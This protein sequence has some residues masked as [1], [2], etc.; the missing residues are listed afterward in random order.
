MKTIRRHK[1][2]TRYT[3]AALVTMATMV[4]AANQWTGGGDNTNW[5][6][7]ANWSAGVPAADQEVSLASGNVL[8]TN[9][10]AELAAFTM[11]GGTLTFSNWTTR[12]RATEVV[13]TDTATLTHPAQS[14]T[15]TNTLGEWVPD[16][17]VW[18]VCSNFTL[19]VEAAI[20]ADEKG[21]AGSMGPGGGI[22]GQRQGGGSYGGRGGYGA[23]GRAVS[24]YGSVHA[25]VSPGSGGGYGVLNGG[26][27]GGAV[28]IQASGFVAIH[29]EI[30][31]N[32]QDYISG[33]AGGGSGG[34]IFIECEEFDASAGGLL[35]AKGGDGRTNTAG[36]GGGGRISVTYDRLTGEPTIRFATL[37]GIGVYDDQVS[38]RGWHLLA[39]C[40][41][42][43]V[44]DGT[45]IGDS[46]AS[47]RFDG[48]N[49][50]F[51][52]VS[53]WILDGLNIT[54][55]HLVLASPGFDLTVKQNLTVGADG[56]FGVGEV[57]GDSNSVVTV[58]NDL[59]VIDGGIFSV[60]AGL[61]SEDLDDFGARVVVSNELFVG[62]SSWVHPYSHRL[63]G[64]SAR[65]IT[66]TLTVESGGGFDA[67]GRGYGY[68]EGPG[69][70]SDSVSSRARGGGHGGRGGACSL[71]VRGGIANGSVERPMRPG[72]GGGYYRGA[73]PDGGGLIYL[74]A[75]SASISGQLLAN[76]AK[77]TGG[78]AGGG[79]VVDCETLSGHFPEFIADGGD[80]D[81]TSFGG[82]GGGRIALHYND[83][84][85]LMTPYF[86]TAAGTG[87]TTG[88]EG[89]NWWTTAGEGTLW[90]S[91]PELLS[92]TLTGERFNQIQFYAGE[93]DSWTVS[94]LTVSNGLFSF[95]VDGFALNVLGDLVVGSDGV[96][97]FGPISGDAQPSLACGG[98]LVVQQDGELRV[99]GGRTNGVD[100]GLGASIE[101]EG[102]LRIETNGWVVP[103]ANQYDGGSPRFR[104][105]SLLVAPGGGFKAAG[106][107]YWTGGGPGA[108]GVASGGGGGGG[109]GGAGGIG[110]RSAPPGKTNGL[111]LAPFGAGSGGGQYSTGGVGGNGGALVWL[112]LLNLCHL[113][114]VI[115]ARGNN[116]RAGAG[117]GS[118]GGILLSAPRF[119]MGPGAELRA[120]GGDSGS[121]RDGNGGGGRIAL[122]RDVKAPHPEWFLSGITEITGLIVTEEPFSGLEGLTASVSPGN[123]GNPAEPGTIRFVDG[124]P[125]GTLI[126]LR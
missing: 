123:Y 41:T 23:F 102:D 17:R 26:A 82:G 36:G 74:E 54:G 92:E 107:G 51:Q 20:D 18:I 16:A 124:R 126:L 52:N 37:P 80:G 113:E 99:Y 84:S 7:E 95:G 119:A 105:R 12:L 22:D 31:A 101:I 89:V 121:E 109:Y 120:D 59:K 88:L 8:L 39:Q 28:R 122:W 62:A 91:T 118:G 61:A 66:D 70:G 34:A 47:G 19:G 110:Y 58:G 55:N 83:I 3:V 76:G 46:P 6:D 79:I 73:L 104:A 115:D 56:V 45:L 57:F 10:T 111:A 9:E 21:Y 64:G 29:G 60:Y 106:V 32:G 98:D 65:F 97:G 108:G 75:V 30:S 116:G 49:L 85:G 50:Y 24:T 72:S 78:G 69:A 87:G 2:A 44:S 25:P 53:E 71:H 100:V 38:T 5:F 1:N 43:S 42:V 4:H 40:G 125:R 68:L 11:T 81:G 14:A 103:F 86:S 112:E 13:L 27:G 48:V 63:D 77:G 114:G 33:S 35:Q 117:G 67:L 96:F 90:C 15:T 93:F 94:E